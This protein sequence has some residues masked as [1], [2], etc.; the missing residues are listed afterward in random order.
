MDTPN[1]YTDAPQ[2]E[3]VMSGRQEKK[4][5]DQAIGW[6]CTECGA[7]A[8]NTVSMAWHRVV[9]AHHTDIERVAA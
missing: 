1:G 4:M 3:G 7:D 6:H 2:K 9:T 5:G 8:S